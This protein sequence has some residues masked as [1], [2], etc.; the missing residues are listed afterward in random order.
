MRKCRQIMSKD[1]EFATKIKSLKTKGP[2]TVDSQSE[3]G[4][5]CRIAK[6]LRQIGTI[7]FRVT[8]RK[9]EDS[10]KIMVVAL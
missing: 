7:D 4:Q 9:T 3:R 2:F 1:F 10:E 5:V 8:T 6:M